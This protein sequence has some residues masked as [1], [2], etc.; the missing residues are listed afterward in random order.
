MFIKTSVRPVIIA[1]LAI[2]A[3]ACQSRL[4]TP[5]PSEMIHSPTNT[6]LPT[7][8]HTVTVSLPTLTPT[9][10][11][12]FTLIPPTPTPTATFTFTP[13]PA[14]S[15]SSPTPRPTKPLASATPAPNFTPSLQLTANELLVQGRHGYFIASKC[16]SQ[17]SGGAEL[18]ID[19]PTSDSLI[20]IRDR[21]QLTFYRQGPDVWATSLVFATS[22]ADYR[23]SFG[24][25]TFTLHR[26][27]Y[28]ANGQQI[29]SCD[30]DWVRQ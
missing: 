19:F 2:A 14:T 25:T 8:T 28:D 5:P 26:E 4:A 12:T 15:T 29:E 24:A 22:R 17:P 13:I 6:R 1:V 16:P 21:S 30:V 3:S 27:V 23:L 20:F 18:T 10:S 7:A 9:A 11:V